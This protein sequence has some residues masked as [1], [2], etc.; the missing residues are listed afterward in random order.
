MTDPHVLDHLDHTLKKLNQLD[1]QD[2]IKQDIQDLKDIKNVVSDLTK[3]IQFTEGQVDSLI[4]THH[5]V[6]SDNTQLK[7]QVKALHYQ[8]SFLTD[9]VTQLDDYSRRENIKIS[10]VTERYR[11]N[12]WDTVYGILRTIDCDNVDIQRCHRVGIRESGKTRDIIVRFMYYPAKMEVMKNRKYLPHN[13][14]INDDYSADT[15]RRISTL[16]PAFKKARSLDEEAKLVGD[17][18]W[19]KGRSYTVD[20]IDQV[21][22]DLQA[23][24]TKQN[25][26]VVAFAGRYSPLS[27]LHPCHISVN[28]HDYTS[29]EQHY[30]HRKCQEAGKHD[31]AAQVLLSSQPEAAMTIGKQVHMTKEWTTSTGKRIMKEG[32]R[33]KFNNPPLKRQLL[34]TRKQDITEATRHPIWGIGLPITSDKLFN[35]HN[36][37][38]NNL[39]GLVLQ[40]V[41]EELTMNVVDADFGDVQVEHMPGLEQ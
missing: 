2:T 1:I 24:S 6:Q 16:R 39:M 19:Y 25:D 28:G 29:N 15:Q 40:E 32:V 10:G 31:I 35:K 30:Q 21:D 12:C 9:K 27:N 20:T 18:L 38:G 22:F 23:M 37:A 34:A 4:T 14:Y 36:W 11:E 7:E 3:S 17:R 5:Q 33:A 41:R 26:K 8:N 13:V